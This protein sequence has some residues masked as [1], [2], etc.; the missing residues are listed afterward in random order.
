MK[1]TDTRSSLLNHNAVLNMILMWL[2]DV[3]YLGRWTTMM[4]AG[5]D[6]E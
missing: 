5:G 3:N 1:K 6:R 2:V 4:L